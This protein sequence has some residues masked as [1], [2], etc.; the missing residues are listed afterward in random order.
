MTQSKTL[1]DFPL[2]AGIQAIKDSMSFA[3]FEAFYRHLQDDLPQNS[4]ET[5]R[6][7][8]SL[9]VRWFFPNRRLDSLLA[10]IWQAY[11]DDQL[12]LDLIRATV[13]EIEP[14]VARFVSEVIQPLSPG[15]GFDTVVARDFVT[16]VYGAYKKNSYDRLLVTTRN[17]GF[18]ERRDN[19]WAVAA[20]PTPTDALLILLHARLAPTP[21]IV[22]LSDL[23]A[24]PFWRYLGL[25]QPDEVRAILHDAHAAGLLARYSTVDQLEQVTT[26]FTLNEYFGRALRLRSLSS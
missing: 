5:R 13:L 6:R 25:R 26:R 17:L 15:E 1:Q 16:A 24:E 18:I 7:Y 14:V 12:L 19:G 22:R 9:L 8:A 10:L 21:R 3:D 20:V 2:A 11:G 23:L 4:P